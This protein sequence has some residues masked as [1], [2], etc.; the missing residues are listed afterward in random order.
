VF[1]FVELKDVEV[2]RVAMEIYRKMGR[3]TDAVRLALRLNDTKTL[4][5]L[6]ES[7]KDKSVKQQIAFIL[8]RQHV[9]N[10]LESEEDDIKELSWNTKLSDY[11]IRLAKVTHTLSHYHT[12]TLSHTHSFS[13]DYLLNCYVYQSFLSFSFI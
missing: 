9:F 10:A 6:I 13:F 12:I 4:K 5:E 7:T 3:V 2:L 1:F 8:A 11:F